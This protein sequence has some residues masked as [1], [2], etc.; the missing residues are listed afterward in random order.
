MSQ[1]Y[2]SFQLSDRRALNL[3]LP[4][5]S[6]NIAL[7]GNSFVTASK[8]TWQLVKQKGIDALI[9]DSLINTVWTFGSYGEARCSC[10]IDSLELPLIFLPTPKPSAWDAESLR[11]PT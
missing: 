8:E 10:S 5:H 4:F 7:Y 9:N 2:L 3:P 11:T 6:T 1:F